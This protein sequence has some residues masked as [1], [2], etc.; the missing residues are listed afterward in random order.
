CFSPNPHNDCDEIHSLRPTESLSFPFAARPTK[1]SSIDVSIVVPL[2][3]EAESV[4][5]LHRRITD[6]LHG[7]GLEYEIL[8]VDDGSRDETLS[9]ATN[10]AKEDP[11]LRVVEFRANYGQT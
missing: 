5:L 2:Y 9:L 10:L 7:S 3:N 11:R 1:M 8:F 4:A 6:A